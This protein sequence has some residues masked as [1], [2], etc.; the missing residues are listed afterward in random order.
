MATITR[1]K[2]K[3]VKCHCQVKEMKIQV[4]VKI[5]VVWLVPICQLSCQNQ[6]PRPLSCK[7][8][9]H[10]FK[11][12]IL[13]RKNGFLMDCLARARKWGQNYDLLNFQVLQTEAILGLE[14]NSLSWYRGCFD[15]LFISRRS[16]WSGGRTWKFN[17]IFQNYRIF[18]IYVTQL[19]QPISV[20]K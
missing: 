20:G 5:I 4:F 9:W 8:W 16:G 10:N 17:K 3:C 11:T 7:Y 18:K 13:E 14:I 6:S 1:I 2:V 12:W 15:I 19:W